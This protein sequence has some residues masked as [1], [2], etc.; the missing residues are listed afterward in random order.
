MYFGE[1]LGAAQPPQVLEHRLAVARLRGETQQALLGVGLQLQDRDVARRR[2]LDGA[3]ERRPRQRELA[4]HALG[5]LRFLFEA[6]A[7]DRARRAAVGRDQAALGFEADHLALRVAVARQHAA[8]HGQLEREHH[9]PRPE[10]PADRCDVI[11]LEASGADFL[12]PPRGILLP[13]GGRRIIQKKRSCGTFAAAKMSSREFSSCRRRWF[14]STSSSFPFHLRTLPATITVSTLVRSISET[15]APGTLLSGATLMAVASRMMMS[16]SLPGVS[17][18]VLPSSLRCLA[19]LMVANRST[20]RVVSRGGTS[21]ENGAGGYATRGCGGSPVSRIIWF[22]TMRCMFMQTR[23][24]VKKSAVIV[25]STSE[26]REGS[27]PRLCILRMGGM[28]WRMFISI[29]KA[30]E[31]CTPWS[32]TP[33]Q[34]RSDIPVMWMNRLSGPSPSVPLSPPLPWA[35]KSRVGRMLNGERICAATWSPSWRPIFQAFS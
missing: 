11:E 30:T 6:L 3:D 5:Q 9:Q 35:S 2:L 21:T 26:L 13:L 7:R 10:R 1:P 14:R 18:P 27:S 29:G 24:W 33:C 22:T 19:P 28:P 12:G 20:S 32:L 25:T 8:R 31:T 15:T 4:H 34:P 17:E 16:A 23:I